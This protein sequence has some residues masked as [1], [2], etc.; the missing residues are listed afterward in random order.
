[1]IALFI[2]PFYRFRKDV[3]RKS[4]DAKYIV[5]DGISSL[6]Y[7]INRVLELPLFTLIK[8]NL[9]KHEDKLLGVLQKF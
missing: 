4:K 8:V 7:K 3:L 6:Q 2:F 9:N 1:M 5:T